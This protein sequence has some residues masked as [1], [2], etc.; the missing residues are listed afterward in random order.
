LKGILHGQG[1][2]DAGDPGIPGDNGL[3][4]LFEANG[5]RVELDLGSQVLG[6]SIP[7]EI[8]IQE[9]GAHDVPLLPTL[10]DLDNQ[11]TWGDRIVSGSLLA[12]K[13]KQFDDGLYAAVDM[14]ANSGAG[15][16]GGKATLLRSLLPKLTH[17]RAGPKPTVAGL[18]FGAAR[19]GGL[20]VPISGPFQDTVQEALNKFLKDE[21]RSKPV[22][23]YTW[24]HQLM[25]I[26]QQDRMLQ[27][28]L[29]GKE[30]I[31]AVVRALHGDLASRA[32]YEGYLQLVSRLT[33]PLVREKPDLRE[34]LD[35]LDKG[36]L[37]IP[38]EAYYFFPPSVAH[39]TELIKRLY[40]NRPIPEGFSLIEEMIRRIRDGR[41]SLEPGEHS[42]WYD[43]QTWALQPLVIPE[44]MPESVKLKFDDEY[45]RQLEELFKGILALTR[46]T[47]IKQLEI[48]SVGLGFPGGP[49]KPTLNI[50][51]ELSA[52]PLY[53]HFLRRATTYGFI[54][55]VL[56]KHFGR[57]G[58]RSMNRQ[59]SD[60]PVEKCLDDELDEMAVLFYGASVV[61]A[62]EL[63]LSGRTRSETLPLKICKLFM[64]HGEFLYLGSGR[65]DEEDADAF[66]EWSKTR[67]DR[68]LAADVRMMVPLFYDVQRRM[69]KVWV[70]M[71]WSQRPMSVSF[72]RKPK[73]RVLDK[74]GLDITGDVNVELGRRTYSLA[75]PVTGELYVNK[76]LDRREF[77]KHCDNHR[78][79]EMILKHLI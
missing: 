35:L 65:G 34:L 45:R 5:F 39:E 68:D 30:D 44:K 1:Q 29:E 19:L 10:E 12:Q 2:T 38:E 36:N 25:G 6:I 7:P 32:I 26:F 64:E 11:N 50:F 53:S 16:F 63:G 31:E 42:G 49:S 79:P 60:G 62:R 43:Y 9:E 77:R 14:A 23:F 66:I 61:V 40:G 18:L 17:L 76:I 20:D 48:P 69:T 52:E 28:E 8:V 57:E 58:L 51:P 24:N 78:S 67:N 4:R 47:H 21:L 41:L 73:V 75:Y 71:G 59:T 72:F 15:L 54:R 27:Q 33:N 70:F 74:K 56:E 37:Q 13:A 3:Y 22:G 46:E 55:S